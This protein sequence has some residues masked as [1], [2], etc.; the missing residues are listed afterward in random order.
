MSILLSKRRVTA[1][2]F[3]AESLD[4]DYGA[5]AE[6]V[7]SAPFLLLGV[8]YRVDVH[9]EPLSLPIGWMPDPKCA[10]VKKPDVI[11]VGAGVIG[12]ACARLLARRGAKVVVLDRGEPGGEASNAAAG[13]LAPLGE[14]HEPGP[15]FDLLRESA[16][17]FPALAKELH[18]ET[19]IDV[20]YRREGLLEVAFGDDDERALR[21]RAR[22]IAAR[23]LS[24][25]TWDA[26]AVREREPAVA[27]DVR[28][29]LFLPDDHRVDPVKL[30]LALWRSAADAGAEFRLGAPVT[31]VID[32]PNGVEVG[33]ERLQASEVVIAAGAFSGLIPGA[34]PRPDD[35]RPVRG[36]MVAVESSRRLLRRSVKSAHAYLVPRDDG[37]ILIGATVEDVGFDRTVT[38]SAVRDL[39]SAATRIVPAIAT[40]RFRDAWSGLR[41]RSSTDAPII[42]RAREGLVIA[43]GHFRNGIVLAPATAKLVAAIVSQG[44]PSKSA[45]SRMHSR[46]VR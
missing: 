9:P 24:V 31:R 28:F 32:E 21:E 8:A 29:G 18:D 19:G 12:C 23:G 22:S 42:A 4:G 33:G 26:S 39:L 13:M 37:R 35:V 2:G 44:A 41:P 25:E 7:E 6:L 15:F 40:C 36:Q 43:T 1:G 14:A 10:S 17:M 34:L 38:A 5:G 46:H 27:E 45:T 3:Y 20:E 16:A 11:I 30:T